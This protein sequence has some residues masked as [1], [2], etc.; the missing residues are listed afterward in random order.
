MPVRAPTRPLNR[1]RPFLVAALIAAIAVWCA[2]DDNT[3]QQNILPPPLV[4]RSVVPADSARVSDTTLNISFTFNRTI[5]LSE[6]TYQIYPTPISVGDMVAFG[7]G[8]T[9]TWTDV[10]LDPSSHAHSI[11]LAGIDLEEPHAL[12]LFTGHPDS[13]GKFAGHVLTHEDFDPSGAVVYA[14]DYWSSTFNPL[15]PMPPEPDQIRRVTLVRRLGPGVGGYAMGEI[16]PDSLYMVVAIHDT[17]HDARFDPR[18][19]WWGFYGNQ[20][21]NEPDSVFAAARP[22][23]IFGNIDFRLQAPR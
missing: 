14:L 10:Q 21:T 7:A 11:L 22:E 8:R 15:Q 20:V 23:R 1:H 13:V 17:N 6:I 5:S 19:D 2:C 18:I 12:I 4:L 3:F 16:P 9:V